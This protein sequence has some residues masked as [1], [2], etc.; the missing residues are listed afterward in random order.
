[1]KIKG[2]SLLLG[3][4]ILAPSF[5]LAAPPIG[6]PGGV[7]VP[8]PAWSGDIGSFVYLV[9][10]WIGVNW[11]GISPAVYNWSMLLYF[12]IIPFLAI[13]IIVY[14]FLKELRIFRRSRNL[15]GLLAFLIAFMTVP[16]NVLF[17]V[18]NFL[19]ILMG[20]W[21]VLMFALLFGVGAYLYM[22]RRKAQWVSS[23]TIDE[24]EAAVLKSTTNEIKMILQQKKELTEEMLY[25][26]NPRRMAEISKQLEKLNTQ[27]NSLR[28]KEKTV[29]EV[30]GQE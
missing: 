7:A 22:I 24:A 6:A 23:A 29:K 16:T 3:L 30:T 18:V 1:L 21:S 28:S 4:M 11:F 8:F 5:V 13:W 9:F 2:L 25:E 17:W 10:Q 15:N 27:L 12:G 14:A 20:Y 19:F 26:E